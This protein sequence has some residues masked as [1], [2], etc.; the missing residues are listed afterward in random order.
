[1]QIIRSIFPV[2]AEALAHRRHTAAKNQVKT[3]PPPCTPHAHPACPACCPGSSSWAFA[4]R[5]LALLPA[6]E[7]LPPARWGHLPEDTV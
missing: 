7:H 6:A 5:A 4:L 2:Q 1:M 3:L